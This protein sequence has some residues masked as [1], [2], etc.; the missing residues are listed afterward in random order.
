MGLADT[1]HPLLAEFYARP[2]LQVARELIG[3]TLWSRVDGELTSGV[4]VE[5]EAYVA[6]ID[7]A[8]H[9]YRGMTARTRTMFGR[10]GHAYVY[11]SYGMHHCLN[12][13]TEPEGEAAAILVR[14]LEPRTGIT[15]MRARRGARISDR[16][17]CRGPGRLCQALGITLTEDGVS[18]AGPLLWI[19]GTPDWTH[20]AVATSPRIGITRAVE[21]PWRFYVPGSRYVSRGAPRRAI[22]ADGAI[23]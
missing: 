16:D 3:K 20:S 14:A 10:P 18:L 8:A 21:W 7:P 22:A 19:T 1:A 13:V 11:I 12:V 5:T 9:G 4:I 15:V 6:A 23:Q 2:T 17:L